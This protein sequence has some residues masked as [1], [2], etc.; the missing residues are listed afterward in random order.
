MNN[1]SGPRRRGTPEL[2][3]PI[4]TQ[5]TVD[6]KVTKFDALTHNTFPTTQPIAKLITKLKSTQRFVP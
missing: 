4:S 5:K 3:Y 6:P 2:A 1:F